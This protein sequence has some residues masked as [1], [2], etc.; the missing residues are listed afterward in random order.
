MSYTASMLE[1]GAKIDERINIL[2]NWFTVGEDGGGG[3]D[4]VTGNGDAIDTSNLGAGEYLK[5]DGLDGGV[6]GL[7]DTPVNGIFDMGSVQGAL[8]VGIFQGITDNVSQ[9]TTSQGDQHKQVTKAM[10]NMGK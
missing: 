10:Q 8:A 4:I 5:L 7:D 3:D 1:V 9:I 2:D 6:A